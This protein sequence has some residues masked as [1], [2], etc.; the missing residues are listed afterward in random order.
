MYLFHV[1]RQFVYMCNS[2]LPFRT[3]ELKLQRMVSCLVGVGIEL[4]SSESSQVLLTAE[5]FCR[6]QEKNNS[7][8]QTK[9]EYMSKEIV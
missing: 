7:N 6:S 4:Q 8:Y 2:C 5:S 1:H 9:T 3:L